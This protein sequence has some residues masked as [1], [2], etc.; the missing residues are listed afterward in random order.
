MLWCDEEYIGT[1]TF[2][3]YIIAFAYDLRTRFQGKE[4]CSPDKK[5]I[6]FEATI[7]KNFWHKHLFIISTVYFLHSRSIYNTLKYL[8]ESFII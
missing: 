8:S 5:K 4:P 2:Y 1:V 6:M 3:F 7:I